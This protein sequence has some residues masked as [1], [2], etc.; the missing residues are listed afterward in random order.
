HWRTSFCM[1]LCSLQSRRRP[2]AQSRPRL[3]RAVWYQ[4]G[5]RAVQGHIAGAD[6]EGW[7]WARRSQGSV[8]WNIRLGRR[9]LR[10]PRARRSPGGC[11]F[12][13][14][15]KEA[16]DKEAD[17]KEADDKEADDKGRRVLAPSY[18]HYTALS[19]ACGKPHSVSYNRRAWPE[20]QGKGRERMGSY[21]L[22][23]Q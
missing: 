18:F 4:P 7:G 19:G 17:D 1:C 8:R 5:N 16:D 2:G 9:N 23:F 11:P 10:T 20:T 13:A 15:D 14:D 6:H 3:T 22:G 21:I 12:T